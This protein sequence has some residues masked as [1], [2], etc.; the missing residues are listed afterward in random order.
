MQ[1][2]NVGIR[3][4]SRALNLPT[5]LTQGNVNQFCNSDSRGLVNRDCFFPLDSTPPYVRYASQPPEVSKDTVVFKW[6]STE[7]ASFE[8]ALDD[9]SKASRC[10]SGTT[11]EKRLT[12]LPK[13]TRV[14]YVRGTDNAG[15]VGQFVSHYWTV[16]E[17]FH[18]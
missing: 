8:C 4:G 3:D 12:N 5:K 14:F 13:G 9:K 1:L 18:R 17:F 2:S 7:T 6:I 10:G 11:G 16:G 15:N